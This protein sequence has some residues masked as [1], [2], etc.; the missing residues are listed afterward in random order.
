M[1]KGECYFDYNALKE[2]LTGVEGVARGL[3]GTHLTDSCILT[4]RE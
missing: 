4:K 3:K 2:W 1:H